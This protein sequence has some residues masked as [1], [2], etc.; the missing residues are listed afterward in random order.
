MAEEHEQS[1]L[2]FTNEAQDEKKFNNDT[3]KMD[4]ILGF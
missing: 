4:R 3:E 2:Y 1:G